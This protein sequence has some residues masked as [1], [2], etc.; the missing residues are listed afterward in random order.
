VLRANKSCAMFGTEVRVPFLDQDVIQA[1]VH[2]CPPEFKMPTPRA[3]GERPIEKFLLREAFKDYLPEAIC[4][5]QKEQFSDGVGQGWIAKIKEYAE[6]VISD[7]RFD[8]RA[9]RYP[10]QTP[11]TKEGLLYRDLFEEIFQGTPVASGQPSST[12]IYTAPSVACSSEAALKWCAKGNV[13]DPS[14]RSVL[15]MWDKKQ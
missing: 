1:V 15:A 12:A 2:D 9:M 6:S 13:I 3:P 5:R 8:E 7:A 4:W 14:G 10:F 11:A